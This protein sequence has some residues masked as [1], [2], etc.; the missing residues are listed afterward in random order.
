MKASQQIDHQRRQFVGQSTVAL[1]AIPLAG[2]ASGSTRYN[3]IN[4]ETRRPISATSDSLE[5]VRY[6]TLAAN[7]HNTQPWRFDVSQV[8][9]VRIIP[10]LSRRTPVVDPDDHHVYASLGCAA[11][12][13]AIAATAQ[14]KSGEVSFES[15]DNGG[16]VVDLSAT[17]PKESA[18]FKAITQRQVTRAEYAGRPVPAEV[19]ERLKSAANSY[20]VQV[21]MVTEQDQMEEVLQLVLDGNSNQMDNPDFVQ[22]LKQWIRFNG[23]LAARSRDGLYVACSGNSEMPG[24]IAPTLFGLFFNKDSENKKYAEHIRSS[25]GLVIFVADSN[26]PNGWFNAGRAYQRFALQATVDGVKHAFI[27]QTV[28]VPA[29]RKQLQDLFQLGGQRPNLVVRFGYGPTMPMSLRRSVKDVLV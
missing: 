13:L 8:N 9:N 19:L 26:D 22:E 17:R 24:W 27:N 1:A 4:V 18:L 25:S 23:K 15:I 10:D 14:G 16:I 21:Y 5:L 6:A 29:M 2:C 11:E 3:Q 20:G 7:A 12:N 28:E